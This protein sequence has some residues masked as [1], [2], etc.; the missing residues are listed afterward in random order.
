MAEL[1]SVHLM[2]WIDANRHAFAPPVAN[3]EVF[4]D[5]EFIY[6][7]VRGPNARNDF[8]IDPGDE[9]FY[10][11][12]GDIT[13]RCREEA[14]GFRDV[15]VREGEAMLVRAGTPHCPIRPAGTWGLVVERK[16][17]PDELDALAWFCERCGHELY[18]ERF[19]CADIERELKA[20]IERFNA[21]DSLRTCGKCRAVL[22]VPAGASA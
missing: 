1:E 13:V 19:A 2:R 9:I 6:Q 10:Q 5:S 16:R 12:A 14:G 18:R 17:R 4:P 15:R 8:H 20:I 7:I 21:S 22:P 3:K 11:L